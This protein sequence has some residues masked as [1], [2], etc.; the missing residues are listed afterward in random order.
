MNV[1]TSTNFSI[2]QPQELGDAELVRAAVA[3]DTHAF[4]ALVDR[5]RTHLERLLQAVL[6]SRFEL[7][8][9]WQETL[10]R[11]YLNLDSLRDPERFGAWLCSIGLNLA[12]TRRRRHAT[13]LI[14]WDAL[15]DG[16]H[17]STT[18]ALSLEAQAIQQ[19]E[20]ERVRNAIADLPPAERNAIMLVYLGELSHKEAA[21]QLGSTLSAVKVRVHRGRRRLHSALSEEFQDSNQPDKR[22]SIAEP[23]SM[24]TKEGKMIQVD[25]HDILVE[26]RVSEDAADAA[27]ADGSLA[28]GPASE[29]PATK[30]PAID[31][32]ALEKDP[33][34]F[35]GN[36]I[37]SRQIVILK[38]QMGQRVLPIWIGHFE[39]E[40]IAQKLKEQKALRPLTFDLTKALLDFGAIE[41][42]RIVISHLH[43]K[44]YYSNLLARSGD[45]EG[46]I[47]ARPSDAINL[48][49]RLGVP[50]FVSEELMEQAGK[51]SDEIKPKE[52]FGHR[53]LLDET[54]VQ[55]VTERLESLRQE[56]G[57]GHLDEPKLFSKQ[58]ST[59]TQSD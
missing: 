26:Y 41:T 39:A 22:Q 42:E 55:A 8:D 17:S 38:E 57:W 15:G 51:L 30:Q 59:V 10:L 16:E 50:I 35:M 21:S 46:K 7:E 36:L 53:S 9:I 19:E 11:A 47:D 25:I 54:A 20:A 31:D 45:K 34:V 3:G 49:V 2:N 1:M 32:P 33:I 13:K 40:A 37:F 24:Q 28:D 52:G 58:P 43:E 29:Q 6:N 14:S 12:R 4:G 18:S 44:T 23:S 5:H 56:S 27:D 48:A